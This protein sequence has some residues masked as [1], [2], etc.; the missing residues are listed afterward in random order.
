M[1]EICGNKIEYGPEARCVAYCELK[2]GHNKQ[3]GT[4]CA[5][6]IPVMSTKY[7]TAIELNKIYAIQRPT[8]TPNPQG[9]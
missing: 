7:Y 9:Q 2:L 4:Q 6:R 3:D 5:T 1:K 8:P